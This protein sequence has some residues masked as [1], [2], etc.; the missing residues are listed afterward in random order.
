MGK[1]GL[2]PK[3]VQ[4]FVAQGRTL[5]DEAYAAIKRRIISLDLPP[6]APFTEAQVA[7]DLPFSR[8]PV[9]EALARLQLE[10]LVD[11]HSH[12]GYRV[13]PVTLQDVQDQYSLRML[14]EGEAARL[15]ASRPAL[16]EHL[17]TLE[18]L[19]RIV[20]TP[21]DHASI[22]R[23]LQ[24]NRIFHTTIA[25][26]SGNRRLTAILEQLLDQTERLIY[27]GL[28]E[29]VSAE[30]VMSEH[31]ELAGAIVARDPQRASEVAVEQLRRWQAGVISAVL[32][33]ETILLT[34]V[35]DVAHWESALPQVR[36]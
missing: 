30:T 28:V 21:D 17:R 13:A 32:S 27:L 33:S 25:R 22:D 24:Q 19:S 16:G 1:D 3:R 23:A 12:N 9:R 34:N 7:V 4:G 5:T 36:R 14:L 20:Y 8:T 6:G 15:A 29:T 2:V 31:A 35:V 18:E 26:M 11:V 10:G